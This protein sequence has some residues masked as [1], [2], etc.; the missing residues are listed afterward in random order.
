M[1]ATYSVIIFRWICPTSEKQIIEKFKISLNSQPKHFPPNTPF[2][3]A[4]YFRS[5]KNQITRLFYFS[6]QSRRNFGERLISILLTKIFA[7]IFS[8]NGSGRLGRK[9][10]LY[11]EGGRRS[12]TRR[13]VR[14]GKQSPL[15]TPPPPTP[16][17]HSNSKSNM[18]GRINDRS[19]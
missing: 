8:F 3:G 16:T 14:V 1:Y 4:E 7:A 19:R 11:Q 12:K 13:E 6:P 15:V 5:L 10:K 17:V 18:D 2:G 9:K